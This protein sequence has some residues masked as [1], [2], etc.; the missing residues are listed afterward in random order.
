MSSTGQT[1][2]GAGF[3][4]GG[5]EGIRTTG[6]LTAGRC[7]VAVVLLLVRRLRFLGAL[8][9]WAF[10]GVLMPGHPGTICETQNVHRV[11]AAFLGLEPEPSV[12]ESVSVVSRQASTR[13]RP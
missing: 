5:A 7:G 3:L 4:I 11:V 2:S 6:L 12:G 13:R 9:G 10:W 8:G 1:V